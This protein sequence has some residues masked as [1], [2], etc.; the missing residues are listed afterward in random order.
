MARFLAS[1]GCDWEKVA[2]VMMS[3]SLQI[4]VSRCGLPKF[5]GG[6]LKRDGAKT[7]QGGARIYLPDLIRIRVTVP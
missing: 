6:S 2:F 4:A 5:S 7:K 3:T 1:G